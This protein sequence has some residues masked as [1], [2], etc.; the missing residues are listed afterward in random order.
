[1]N[2]ASSR[3]NH[4]SAL[5]QQLLFADET[6]IYLFVFLADWK[7]RFGDN[8]YSYLEMTFRL[9]NYNNW[10]VKNFSIQY[11]TVFFYTKCYKI[12]GL[13]FESFFSIG[14]YIGAYFNAEWKLNISCFISSYNRNSLCSVKFQIKT[15]IRILLSK[16]S[17]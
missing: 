13:N 9:Y 5:Y 1:M 11:L 3:Y 15:N 7:G 10:I 16:L 12:K 6:W 14:R 17:L 4:N 8:I 2:Y